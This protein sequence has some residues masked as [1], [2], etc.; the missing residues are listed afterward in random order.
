MSTSSVSFKITNKDKKLVPFTAYLTPD[1]GNSLN[2]SAHEFS[3]E[4]QSGILAKYGSKGTDI[5][6]S[7]TPVE[8]GKDKTGKL[9]I[10]T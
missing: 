6:I 9:V 1:S 2:N 7:F 5:K 4:P 10:E 8:Y 3:V